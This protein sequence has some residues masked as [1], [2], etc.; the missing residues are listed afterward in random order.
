MVNNQLKKIS[1]NTD[2][3]TGIDMQPKM[4]NIKIL[5]QDLRK[6]MNNITKTD[7]NVPSTQYWLDN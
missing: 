3:S 6:L 4:L 2:Y 1:K 5:N 7:N